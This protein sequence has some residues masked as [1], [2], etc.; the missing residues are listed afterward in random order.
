MLTHINY[1]FES[2]R[3]CIFVYEGTIKKSDILI[4]MYD[5]YYIVNYDIS[6]L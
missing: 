6:E 3:F 5:Q 2:L 4:N 1:V